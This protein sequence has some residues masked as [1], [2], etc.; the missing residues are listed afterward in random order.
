MNYMKK[1]KEEQAKRKS[2]IRQIG[3]LKDWAIVKLTAT[4]KSVLLKQKPK[5][6]PHQVM[7]AKDYRHLEPEA[8]WP[9]WEGTTADGEYLLFTYP[10]MEAAAKVLWDNS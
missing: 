4:G 8:S 10:G 3:T 6:E 9:I 7:I 5:D 2:A 1:W